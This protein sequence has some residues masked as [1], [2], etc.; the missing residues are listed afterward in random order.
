MKGLDV[1]G[2]GGINSLAKD[3]I[4]KSKILQDEP[5]LDLVKD[6][7]KVVSLHDA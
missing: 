1:D 7:V 2:G 3:F 4:P 5:V 6:Q